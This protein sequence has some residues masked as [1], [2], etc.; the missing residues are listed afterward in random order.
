[1]PL[2]PGFQGDK[3]LQPEES[4]PLCPS[5][6]VTRHGLVSRGHTVAT[7]QEKDKTE[8]KPWPAAVAALM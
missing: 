6:L 3:V 7:A 8:S 5:N 2:T 1:M 4:A